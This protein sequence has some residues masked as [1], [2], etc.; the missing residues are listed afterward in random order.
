[1]HVT[2]RSA[3]PLSAS[4]LAAVG[5]KLKARSGKDIVVAGETDPALIG[6]F[7]IQV[8]DHIYDSTVAT[9]LARFRHA[10]IHA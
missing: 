1:M 5:E 7:S 9:L 6:G 3:R 2:V 4:Q 8:G 10:L